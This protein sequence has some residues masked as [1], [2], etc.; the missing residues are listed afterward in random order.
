RG[1]IVFATATL[2][3]DTASLTRPLIS[4]LS[5]GVVL[6][7]APLGVESRGELLRQVTETLGCRVSDD[8]L[9]ALAA[10]L[11][12][13]PPRLLSAGVELRR[14][15]GATIDAADAARFLDDESQGDSPPL[16]EILAAAARY[17]GVTQKML[18]SASRRQTVVLARAVAVYLARR[19]T[20]L[21]Y[22]EIGRSLGNRDHT[23]ILHNYRRIENSLPKDRPLRSA[24]EELQR[25]ITRRTRR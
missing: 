17:Y 19:L 1:L 13:E 21:S 25:Q 2:P 12:C 15:F 8:A 10:R 7:I 9:D 20:P 11:P 18:T 3:V 4:R 24:V 22:Q 14:R 23:T 6:E 5:G 16:K